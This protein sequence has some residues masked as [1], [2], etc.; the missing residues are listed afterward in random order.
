MTTYL[1]FRSIGDSLTLDLP[2]VQEAKHTAEKTPGI[3]RVETLSGEVIWADNNR[4]N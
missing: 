1:F 2:N 4:W 3:T